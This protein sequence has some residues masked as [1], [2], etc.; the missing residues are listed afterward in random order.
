MEHRDARRIPR[1]LKTRFGEGEPSHAGFTQNVSETGLF[2]TT[3][4]LPAIGSTL[5]VQIET[6]GGSCRL[7]G[8][9]VRH[10]MVPMELRSM[11]PQGFGLRLFNDRAAVRSMLE[12]PIEP[13]PAGPPVVRFATRAAYELTRDTELKRGGLTFT[14]GAPVAV[15][16]MLEVSLE[17]PW[18]SEALLVR[19]RVVHC[20]PDGQT[21]VAII[22]LEKP[23]VALAWLD[24]T[25]SA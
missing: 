2:I 8:Q 16:E 18:R 10:V 23:A 7:H 15:N 21:F 5:T 6:S 19:G 24:A 14:T 20:R 11:K 1:R 22:L 3:A 17:V 12:D 13:E 4:R 9:V 25:P